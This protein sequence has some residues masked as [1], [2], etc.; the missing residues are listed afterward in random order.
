LLEALYLLLEDSYNDSEEV[1]KKKAKYSK[2]AK[3]ESEKYRSKHPKAE[4]LWRRFKMLLA[5]KEFAQDLVTLRKKI[6]F[7]D[8]GYNYWKGDLDDYFVKNE[9][10]KKSDAINFLDEKYGPFSRIE[11][12]Y[13]YFFL[14]F[15]DS[16][17]PYEQWNGK[18]LYL[19]EKK[20]YTTLVSY[21]LNVYPEATKSD[22]AS[23]WAQIKPDLIR[24]KGYSRRITKKEPKKIAIQKEAYYYRKD[25][26]LPL[27]TIADKINGK[28]KTSYEYYE[29]GDLI[30]AYKKHIGLKGKRGK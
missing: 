26:K 23:L 25:Q 16:P 19:I 24:L 30:D 29:I 15:G 4:K 28:F 5:D 1:M 10:P 22:L 21:S 7:P 14:K 6:G 8:N 9:W 27:K 13:M 18:G 11:R 12:N 3:Q 20:V 2:R 17:M